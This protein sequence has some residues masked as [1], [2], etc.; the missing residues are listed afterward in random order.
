MVCT[1][2]GGKLGRAMSP[3][4]QSAAL[5]GRAT[6]RLRGGSTYVARVTIAGQLVTIDDARLRVVSMIGGERTVTYRPAAPRT[7]SS[8][9]VDEIVWDGERGV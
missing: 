6:I 8:W 9:R 1:G 5:T 3:T 7:L 2:S 4:L